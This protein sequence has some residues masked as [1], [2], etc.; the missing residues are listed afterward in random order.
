MF[1]HPTSSPVLVRVDEDDLAGR[2]AA[3]EEVGVWSRERDLHAVCYR[4]S[5]QHCEREDD[6]QP[7]KLRGVPAAQGKVDAER[8]C[9][10]QESNE[11]LHPLREG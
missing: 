10:C 3:I 5:E 7:I 6:D 1:V 2:P 8:Q 11:R 4:T 9:G